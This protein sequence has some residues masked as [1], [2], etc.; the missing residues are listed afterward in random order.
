V[1]GAKID[2]PTV[3]G[4][5]LSVKVPPGTSTGNRLRLRG[6]GVAGGDQYLE[7]AVTVPRQMD[8]P[9]RKLIEEFARLNPQEPR[10]GAPW[11]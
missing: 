8:E 10:H 7:F 6:M 11:E 5:K 2:V 3:N 9:S 4:K 1:L